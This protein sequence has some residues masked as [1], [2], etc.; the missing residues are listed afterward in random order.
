MNHLLIVRISNLFQA[1]LL[2]LMSQASISYVFNKADKRNI[3][4]NL[5]QRK[6]ILTL[7]VLESLIKVLQPDYSFLELT[8][9]DFRLR[10][11]F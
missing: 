11:C 8:N 3:G 6:S 2:V 5:I 4:L 9:N 10:S 1:F 7:V